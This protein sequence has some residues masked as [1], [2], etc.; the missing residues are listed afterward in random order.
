MQKGVR[1][2]GRVLDVNGKPVGGIYVEADL[3]RKEPNEDDAV[4]RGVADLKHRAILTAADGTFAFRPLPAGTYRVYASERGWDPSTRDGAHDAPRRPLP[5]VFSPQNVTLKEGEMPDSIEIRAVPHV[6]VEAQVYSSK[7]EKRGFYDLSLVGEV[8]GDFWHTDGHPTADGAYK[9]LAPHGLTDARIMLIMNEHSAVQFRKSKN[10][11]LERGRDIRLGTL[12]RDVK[13]I[14]IVRYESPVIVVGATT[15]D[16]KPIK[17]FRPSVDYTH[18]GRDR[19]GKFI[20]KSGVQSDVSLEEQGDGRYRTSQLVPDREV[21][22][23]VKADG[24]APASR[25]VTLAEGKIEEMTLVL[26]P[27]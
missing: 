3:E 7:G 10:A 20:L 13:D 19:E 24:F 23:T 5:A 4:P 8:D 1:F 21:N 18:D 16:R 15:K 17:D 26:E 25:K 9:I 14:E 12:D 2:G 27:E 6:V 11:P 22:V